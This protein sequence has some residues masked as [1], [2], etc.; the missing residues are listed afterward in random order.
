[1]KDFLQFELDVFE[2]IFT[3]KGKKDGNNKVRISRIIVALFV[4]LWMIMPSG[5]ERGIKASLAEGAL[6]LFQLCLIIFAISIPG[7]IMR[8]DGKYE[9]ER[10]YRTI[11][12]GIFSILVIIIFILYIIAMTGATTS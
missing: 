7:Y 11:M 8:K 12:L 6:N 10:K 9:S 2:E 5:F 1:M 3:W 4:A